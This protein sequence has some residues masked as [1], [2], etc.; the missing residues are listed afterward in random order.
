MFAQTHCRGVGALLSFETQTPFDKLPEWRKLRA[1]PLEEQKRLLRDPDLRRVL[2][3]EANHG[4]YGKAFGPEAAK[5]DWNRIWVYQNPVPPNPLVIELA[6]ARG[7]DPVEVFI[8]LSLEKDFKQYFLSFVTPPEEGPLLEVMRHPRSVMT[9]SDSGAHVSQIV[10]SCIH[11][12]L[13]AH[14]TRQLGAFT[15]EE[16]IRMITLAPARAWG[17]HDRGLLREGMIADINI[18]DPTTLSPGMPE[19]AHD[20]PGKAP[21]LKIKASGILATIVGG[22]IVLLN[23]EHTGQLPGN[24]LRRGRSL[25]N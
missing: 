11:T 15:L 14:W 16:A 12:Y 1:R 18:F 5:P 4:P 23:G 7:V 24:L 13:L 17:L 22:E 3:H 2:V 19:L 10:D 6:K 21:R 20:L 9:F 8:D 25:P